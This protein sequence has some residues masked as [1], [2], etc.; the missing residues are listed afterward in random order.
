MSKR[1]NAYWQGSEMR[2]IPS[3]R[4]PR[5]ALRHSSRQP[6]TTKRSSWELDCMVGRKWSVQQCQ[7]VWHGWLHVWHGW[8][9]VRHGWLQLPVC[10]SGKSVSP[11]TKVTEPKHELRFPYSLLQSVRAL[12]ETLE[13]TGTDRCI[14]KIFSI[15]VVIADPLSGLISKKLETHF[16]FH[17]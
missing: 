1:A 17:R 3:W 5:A 10:R 11:Q 6:W 12:N 4:Q 13:K 16:F 7:H 2:G 14:H 8:L 15:V 9:Y